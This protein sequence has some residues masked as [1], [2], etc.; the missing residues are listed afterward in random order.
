MFLWIADTLSEWLRFLKIHGL[1]VGLQRL[2]VARFYF[3]ILLQ[4]FL[5]FRVDF[6][7]LSFGTPFDQQSIH[8]RQGSRHRAWPRLAFSFGEK[9]WPFW[10]YES[11][12]S[13]CHSSCNGNDLPLETSAGSFSMPPSFPAVLW[14][15]GIH[16]QTDWW[17]PCNKL[18]ISYPARVTRRWCVKMQ[19]FR[20]L[21]RDSNC[22][23]SLQLPSI[24]KRSSLQFVGWNQCQN[25]LQPCFWYHRGWLPEGYEAING[26]FWFP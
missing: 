18:R 19:R 15:Q 1:T 12:Q 9:R 16:H 13:R 25:S 17:I 24:E 10:K 2:Y 23:I 20:I 8:Q 11:R 6:M 3:F 26:C 21:Q 5:H 14:L 4:Q 22:H 7:F